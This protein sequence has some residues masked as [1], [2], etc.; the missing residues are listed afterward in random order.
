MRLIDQLIFFSIVFL[1]YGSLNFYIGARAVSIVPSSYRVMF[2]VAYLFIVLSYIAGRILESTMPSFLST[3]LIWIGSFW[4]AF[5][6]Y[7]FFSV[8]IIDIIRLAN[9]FVGF[10]PEYF[11]NNSEI[12]KRTLAI[13]VVSLVAIT[14]IAGH[15]N[16]RYIK[17]KS[18]L[19]KVDKSMTG[20]DSLNIALVSDIHLG[21]IIGE[22]H[23]KK[24][25][26]M[27]NELDSDVVL[28]A[29][30]TIDEDIAPVLRNN[31]GDILKSFKAK[32]G[33]YGITGN[34]EYI[35]GVEPASKYLVDHGVKLL[36]DSTVLVD[37][38]FYLVGREDRAIG[39]FA[40]KKRKSLTELVKDVNISRPVILMDHQPFAL[41][42]AQENN[43]DLQVSGHTHYGQ[44]WPLNYITDLVYE[45]AWGY[46]AKGKTHYYVSCGAGGWGPPI[47]TGSRPEVVNIRLEFNSQKSSIAKD[48][49]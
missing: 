28:L 29:G 38:K 14:V 34:H 31:V 20:L 12:V 3:S 22:N 23:L 40:G 39:Q 2:I 13:A 19:L 41:N 8:L 47:R 6:V 15:I 37:D 24:I 21:V 45:L 4:L 43:V 35:G 46:R 36:R 11:S 32:Y 42:E 18:L 30:D 49:E 1:I 27:V 44:I 10:L 16:T 25:V 5:M 17:T 26:N 9:H 7:F 33:V 48:K